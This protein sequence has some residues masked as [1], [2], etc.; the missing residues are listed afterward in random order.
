V[1]CGTSTHGL[2]HTKLQPGNLEGHDQ[3][4]DTHIG[5]RILLR[6]LNNRIWEYK[7]HSPSSGYGPAVGFCEYS[8]DQPVS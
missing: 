3:L 2:R 5:E 4:G 8:N 1:A 6:I 7:L